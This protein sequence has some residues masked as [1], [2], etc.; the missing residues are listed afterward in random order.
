MCSNFNSMTFSVNFSGLIVITYVI[1]LLYIY[2][3]FYW[4]GSFITLCTCISAYAL[5]AGGFEN[6]YFLNLSIAPFLFVV[7]VLSAGTHACQEMNLLGGRSL[8]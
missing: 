2:L 8:L 6:I 4:A 3:T 5:V 7:V 1:H